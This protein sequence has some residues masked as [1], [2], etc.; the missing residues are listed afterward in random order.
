[1]NFKHS[2]PGATMKKLIRGSLVLNIDR[3]DLRTGIHP[4]NLRRSTMKI[5]FLTIL[6]LAFFSTSTFADN[7]GPAS[8]LAIAIDDIRSGDVQLGDQDQVSTGQPDIAVLSLAK[9]AGF[10]A[11]VDLRGES[12]DRG[13]EEAAEVEALGMRYIS[14]PISGAEGVNF[15]NA[16]ELD[17][18]LAEIDGPVLL[19]CASGNRVGALIA[20][21]AKLHGASNEDALSTGKAAGLTR[22]EPVVTARLQEK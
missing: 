17:R 22:L 6:T 12:E 1:L 11:I 14:L 15:D 4:D 10:S 9:E 3:S 20:L 13:F 5:F 18:V 7:D 19:H 2:T 8:V 16:A 21:R